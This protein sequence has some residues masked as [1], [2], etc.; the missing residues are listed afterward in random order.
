MADVM[1]S[2]D[3]AR[4]AKQVDH[5]SMAQDLRPVSYT[6]LKW[7]KTSRRHVLNIYYDNNAY[8][9]LFKTHFG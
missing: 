9:N 6:H 3:D 2:G 1:A 5:E 4:T 7:I 8:A